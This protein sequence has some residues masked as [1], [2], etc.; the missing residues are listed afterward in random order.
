MNQQETGHEA[1]VMVLG[2][3]CPV[4]LPS[5]NGKPGSKGFEKSSLVSNYANLCKRSS[6]GGGASEWNNSGSFRS[7]R[8]EF[9][10]SD[11]ENAESFLKPGP[12]F[13]AS[14]ESRF[15]TRGGAQ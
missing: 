7:C 4:D 8:I 13:S 2:S 6:A 5:W 12:C 3:P 10:H 11:S 1:G 9:L 14:F 15:G